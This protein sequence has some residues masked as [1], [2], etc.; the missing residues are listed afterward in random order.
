M[1]TA[2]AAGRWFGRRTE[3]PDIGLAAERIVEVV[4]HETRDLPLDGF[5]VA[6]QPVVVPA[7]SFRELLGATRCL[8]DLLRRAMLHLASDRGGRIAAL[9]MDPADCP[10]FVDDEDFEL[11]HCAD[12]ARADVVI[13]TNGPK[14]VE[15]N[16]SGAF[17]GMVQHQAFQRAWRR[18]RD[19]AG[20][21]AFVGV[22]V[23]ARVAMLVE[24][25]C[26]ELGVPPAVLLVDNLDDPGGEVTARHFQVQVDHLRQ[27]GVHAQAADVATLRALVGP[28]G[29]LRHPLGIAQFSVE[30]SR[31]GGHDIGPARDALD[32][33][34]RMIP[35]QSARLLHTKKM[36]AVLSEEQPWMTTA[37]RDLVARYLP[38]TRIVTDRKVL[39]RG[40]PY[41][42]PRLLVERR[43]DF[44]LKGATGFA[45]REVTFGA[46]TAPDRWAALIQD[47]LGS[48]YYVAQEVVESATYPLD[49]MYES[50]EVARISANSVISPFCLG[51]TPAGCFGRFAPAGPPG[52]ISAL[53]SAI[54][55]CLL[56]EV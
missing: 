19:L 5:P 2:G 32:A 43:A 38:W 11:R 39:W 18:I 10:M 25:T 3:P 52:V 44:V 8:L 37:D 27:H 13:G 4:R 6:L 30:D 53:G 35:S 50:G 56:T 42:L 16:V 49:V 9:G 36:L 28:A 40:E 34:F 48:G 26:A 55:G 17:G 33:G 29:S 12:M 41:E 20:R 31:A 24:R 51:G 1:S 14:F 22:D 46:N 54:L 45:G 47:A 15:F 7:E 21:P 23:F